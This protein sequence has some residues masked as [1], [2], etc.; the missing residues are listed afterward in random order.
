VK[1][2]DGCLCQKKICPLN[3]LKIKEYKPTDSGESPL[4]KI[5]KWVNVKCPKCGGSAQRETDVMPNWAGSNWY[6]IR[7]CDPQNNKTLA[8]Q[9]LLKQWMPVDWYNGG[10]E[11]TT[12]HLL[13]SRFIYKFLW[14]IGVIPKS[15]GSEPYKKEL[16]ME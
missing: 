6:Y 8:S 16:R 9:K 12:L 3:C 2:A 11:H 15:I 5:Q 7:F 13:Y 14:D 1:N 4:S 10:M